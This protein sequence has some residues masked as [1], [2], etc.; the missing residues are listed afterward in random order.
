MNSQSTLAPETAPVIDSADTEEPPDGPAPDV[1]SQMSDV[2][3]AVSSL[4]S[5]SSTAV[6]EPTDSPSSDTKVTSVGVL[7]RIRNLSDPERVQYMALELVIGG[8]WNNFLEVGRA[9][10]QIR[11]QELYREDYGT[12]ETYYR[13]KWHFQRS[14][15]YYLIGTAQVSQAL[16]DLPDLPKPDH[17]FQLRPLIG[18][19]PDE[20]RRA[21]QQ[22]ASKVPGGS[23]TAR[24]VKEAMADLQPDGDA[25]AKQLQ[26]RHERSERRRKL[27]DGMTE[28][29][30]LI[31]CKTPHAVL[32]QKAAVVDGHVR[33]FFPKR[34]VSR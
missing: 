19:K 13:N 2:C 10:L 24:R 15:V 17:E 26:V 30:Q 1:S 7:G 3:G 29:L 21:W 34:R 5:Q 8:E 12:F 9:L 18:L 31:M 6:P 23:I 33:Y 25:R 22:A 14:K 11:E 27:T 4:Q 20:V 32:I 16:A 28:L